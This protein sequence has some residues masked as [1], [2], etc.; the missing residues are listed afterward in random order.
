[1]Q[2]R[3]VIPCIQTFL[4]VQNGYVVMI[5]GGLV[6][7]ALDFGPGDPGLIQR[8]CFTFAWSLV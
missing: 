7:S 8:L 2:F 3:R 4:L 5:N 6:G 1:M